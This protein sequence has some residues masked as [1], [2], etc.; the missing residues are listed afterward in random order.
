MDVYGHSCTTALESV[1]E[2]VAGTIFLRRGERS[3]SSDPCAGVEQAPQSVEVLDLK[4][5]PRAGR[6]GDLLIR[7]TLYE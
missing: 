1:V 2:R 5:D 6:S 3:G 4:G 7:S